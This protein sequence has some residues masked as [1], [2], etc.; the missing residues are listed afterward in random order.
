MNYDL[1]VLL[2]ATTTISVLGLTIFARNT[3]SKA[4][5]AFLLVAISVAMWSGSNYLADHA[6]SLVLNEFFTRAAFV[7]ASWIGIGFLFFSY[8]FPLDKLRQR[9]VLE[10][11]VVFVLFSI[12]S[13]S[14]LVLTHVERMAVG[15]GVALI[16]GPLYV[17]YGIIFLGLII[18]A[19]SNLFQ[20][21][22]VSNSLHRNQ[23]KF[24][25]FGISMSTLIGVS[26]NL[27]LPV[28]IGNWAT[29]RFGPVAAVFFV[30]TLGYAIVRRRLFDIRLALARSITYLLSLATITVFYVAI[31]FTSATSLL[32]GQLSAVTLSSKVYF[33][34][35]AIFVAIT[36]NPL[37]QFFAKF[38][39]RIFFHDIYE[40]QVVLDRLTSLV[41]GTVDLDKLILGVSRLM[42]ETVRPQFVKVVL[43]DASKRIT[44]VKAGSSAIPFGEIVKG[45][46]TFKSRSLLIADELAVEGH[47]FAEVLYDSNI[48]LVARLQ[49]SREVVGFVLFGTKSNG[50]VFTNQDVNLVRIVSDEL[51]IAIQNSLR[52]KEIK[53]FNNTLQER[54]DEATLK[55][56]ETNK[57]LRALDEA[58]DEFISMASHQMR[59]PLTSVKGYISMILEGYG[60]P[61]KPEQRKLLSE[62]YNSSQRMVYLIADFLSVSRIRTDKFT[63]EPKPVRLTEVIQDEINQLKVTAQNRGLQLL[64]TAP[65]HF[66]L[67]MLDEEKMRQVIMN[68]IDNAIYYTQPGGA[69]TVT[70]ATTDKEIVF[71]VQDTGV[72]VPKDEQ[73]KLFGKFFRA[74]NAIK[75]R[76]DGTGI[77]LFL[78][79]K[80]VALQGGAMIFESKEGKGSTF[81]FR[82]AR[83]KLL[84]DDGNDKPAY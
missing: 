19:L 11:A 21:Y 68:L 40:T 48:G 59:T 15:T 17:G 79:R 45:A 13:G 50:S 77:G 26:T 42:H 49:T 28:V 82:F 63:I 41:V 39:R 70:L 52:F 64:Y 84:V 55:L 12:F 44:Y 5:W 22:K 36:F 35:A 61:L 33:I 30:A 4:N 47:K 24:I 3:R 23:I 56:R 31:I 32:D 72:G 8:V 57:K 54:I 6:G 66:P 29:S 34:V 38:T 46:T 7:T 62:A 9:Q 1:I 71:R 60:G 16:T 18:W 43:V 81:G 80:I 51:A 53:K 75:M 27:V 76:P 20:S 67:L 25:A 69:V 74:A 37:K 58:K 14:N 78:A 10:M 65:T 83:H 73:H 2:S